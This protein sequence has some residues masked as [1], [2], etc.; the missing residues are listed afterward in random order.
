MAD[1]DV[2][3]G[4]ELTPEA[5]ALKEKLDIYLA[6]KGFGY[7]PD[8]EFTRAMLE[9]LA[10][11]ARQHGAPYC[12][13]RLLTGRPELDQRIACP[14]AYAEQEVRQQ[15]RCHCQLI[16]AGRGGER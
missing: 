1:Q 4:L 14:C 13:C 6:E 2:V 15:G 10:A 11:R 16:V 5:R 9:G 12:S 3:Q 7:N 8:A